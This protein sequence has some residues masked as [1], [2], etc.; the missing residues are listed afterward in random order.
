M[1]DSGFVTLEERPFRSGDNVRIAEGPLA[2]CSGVVRT[3]ALEWHRRS[4]V[5]RPRIS[6]A[7]LGLALMTQ[8]LSCDATASEAPPN[9]AP[10]A[11]A[12]LRGELR[13]FLSAS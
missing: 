13:Q 11:A 4:V 10:L 5:K 2:G 3:P 9:P 12:G 6:R 8:F 1:D 7:L